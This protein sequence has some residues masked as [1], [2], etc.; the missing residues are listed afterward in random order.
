MG[1]RSFHRKNIAESFAIRPMMSQSVFFSACNLNL[2]INDQNGPIICFTPVFLTLLPLIV[3]VVKTRV[4][5]C[6]VTIIDPHRVNH[7]AIVSL[8]KEIPSHALSSALTKRSEVRNY[9]EINYVFEG[10]TTLL[11]FVRDVATN[12]R[13]VI[14]LLKEYEDIRYRMKSVEDRQKCQVEALKQNSRFSS[15]VYI[16]LARLCDLDLEKK[17]LLLS[18]IIK[19]PEGNLLDTNAEYGLVMQWLPMNRRLNY[20]LNSS[21]A[22]THLQYMD[23]LSEKIAKIHNSDLQENR[24]SFFDVDWGSC[25]QLQ[26]KLEH[27]FAFFDRVLLEAQGVSEDFYNHVRDLLLRMKTALTEVFRQEYFRR[28]FEQRLSRKYILHCHGDLKASN[29]WILS[30][31]NY[32]GLTGQE[33]VKV[34]DAVDF[35]SSY[36]NIDVL[37]DM[38][39]LAI[40]IEVRTSYRVARRFISNYLRLTRQK[41]QAAEGVLAYY[42]T[43]RAMI[44]AIV[45]IGYDKLPDIGLQY[46]QVAERHLQN[47]QRHDRLLRFAF[48]VKAKCWQMFLRFIDAPEGQTISAITYVGNFVN[49][50]RHFRF[51]LGRNRITQPTICQEQTSQGG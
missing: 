4:R 39:M 38:A 13:V 24:C 48:Q 16:G 50:V 30:P 21:C 42:L 14:K 46:L 17:E 22:S 20:L 15:D 3:L 41:N 40:D 5:Y 7:D 28:C 44:G 43:E 35:N 27:N 8:S 34:L 12:V 31:E 32:N 36:S 19:K 33:R 11:L 1:G 51:R 10:E 45:S 47:L 37:C 9:Y 29:I 25:V 6:M 26:Q 18:E 2:A 49:K 23:I